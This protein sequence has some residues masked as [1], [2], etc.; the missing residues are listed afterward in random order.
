MKA[1]WLTFA[2]VVIALSLRLHALAYQWVDLSVIHLSL[3]VATLSDDFSLVRSERVGILNPGDSIAA[4]DANV[5][6]AFVA[7]PTVDLSRLQ[8]W[9]IAAHIHPLDSDPM[10][11]CL[12]PDSS[13]QTMKLTA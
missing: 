5:S 9:T 8:A 10:F 12:L 3:Y 4:L 2:V 11:W 13:N 7:T 1:R 6:F